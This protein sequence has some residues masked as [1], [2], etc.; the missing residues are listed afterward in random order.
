M[1]EKNDE[2]L[3]PVLEMDTALSSVRLPLDKKD[4]Q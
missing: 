3:S 1:G 4:D 2:Y